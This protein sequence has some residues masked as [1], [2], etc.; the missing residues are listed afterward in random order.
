MVL[1]GGRIFYVEEE[2]TRILSWDLQYLQVHPFGMGK[3][4]L[5]Y[6]SYLKGGENFFSRAN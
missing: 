2:Q 1:K 5:N 6:F 3:R 4:D